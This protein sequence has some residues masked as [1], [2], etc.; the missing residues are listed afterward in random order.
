MGQTSDPVLRNFRN[1]ANGFIESLLLRLALGA[2][3]GYSGGKPQK[4]QSQTGGTV[5]HFPSYLGTRCHPSPVQP[6]QEVCVHCHWKLVCGS[7]SCSN[8]QAQLLL[9]T[10]QLTQITTFP[11]FLKIPLIGC[12]SLSRIKVNRGRVFGYRI[13][14]CVLLRAASLSE[15]SY[16]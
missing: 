2:W 4:I 16:I 1:T 7:S 12:F 13:Q 11:G 3:R 8:Q 9:L 10:L 6:R 15:E 5:D 14:Q